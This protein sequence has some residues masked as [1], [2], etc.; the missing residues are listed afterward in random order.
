MRHLLSLCLPVGR[1]SATSASSGARSS[2]ST[3]GR[4]SGASSGRGAG[5]G[6]S[7]GA[8]SR[9][10]GRASGSSGGSSRGSGGG[11]SDRG[12]SGDD[13]RVSGFICLLLATTCDERE[14]CECCHSKD[15]AKDVI[16]IYKTEHFDIFLYAFISSLKA[17][18]TEVVVPLLSYLT[19]SSPAESSP[20]N[21]SSSIV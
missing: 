9:T 21:H 18:S 1:R 3:S 11:R 20:A 5:A 7:C 14:C 10:R 13:R 4:A 19:T 17:E 6:A 16:T 8:S 2:P 15:R 12:R